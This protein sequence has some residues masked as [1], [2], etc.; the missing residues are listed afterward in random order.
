MSNPAPT[1]EP[2]EQYG[3]VPICPHCRFKH[4]DAWEWTA[5][6]GD[7]ECD[8]CEKPFSYSR[9]VTVDYRTKPL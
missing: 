2:T 1:A 7:R 3:N 9:I 6:V 4:R 8:S 5:D